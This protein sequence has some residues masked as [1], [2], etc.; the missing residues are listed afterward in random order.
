MP[1]TILLRALGYSS[2]EQILGLFY[3]TTR[4]KVTEE[5]KESILGN[6]NAKS[7]FNEETGEIIIDANEII[8][9]EKWKRLV[10]DKIDFIEVL[11]DV[12]NPEKHDRA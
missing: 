3:D 2:D 10:H 6:V 7:V 12:P 5:N 8:T 9:E 4:L 1:A 11:K